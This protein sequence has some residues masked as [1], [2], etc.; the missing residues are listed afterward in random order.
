M[1][2][3]QLCQL[4][5]RNDPRPLGRLLLIVTLALCIATSKMFAY[6]PVR[7]DLGAYAF[8]AWAVHR[9]LRGPGAVTAS[10][11]AAAMLSREF[12]VAAMLF[13]VHRFLRLRV[14]WRSLWLT[15][16]PGTAL[17]GPTLLWSATLPSAA[18]GIFSPSSLARNAT[19]WNDSVFV[20]FFLYFVVT[21]F[22]GISI[23]LT[24]RGDAILKTARAEPEWVTF[25]APIA[26]ARR[27]ETRT[28]G[29][30]S[31][32]CFRRRSPCMPRALLNG[33]SAD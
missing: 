8:I 10:A 32:T 30:T 27:S 23:V 6:Y 21:T 31:R 18:A 13:G 11:V 3:Y 2:W 7:I 5:K 29:D 1:L 17:L 16:A 20:T 24:T 12:G 22:G 19:Y 4:Y 26:L 33:R 9:V 14:P 25:A 15:V 28:S